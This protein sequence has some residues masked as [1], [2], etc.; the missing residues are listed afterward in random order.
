[1]G[2]GHALD[3]F[4]LASL[5][6]TNYIQWPLL[7]HWEHTETVKQT[8]PPVSFGTPQFKLLV[9]NDK[10]CQFAE[11][12]DQHERTYLNFSQSLD[13][14]SRRISGHLL[15]WRVCLMHSV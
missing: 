10:Q 14:S 13:F 6:N 3:I 9:P 7:L 5:K 1:M 11:V 15:S 12:L 4:Q 2:K 8:P